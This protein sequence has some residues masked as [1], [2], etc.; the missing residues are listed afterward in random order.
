MPKAT[1]LS[2]G[3]VAMLRERQFAHMAT[4]M[5]DGSPQTTVVWIDVEA[6]GAHILVNSSEKRLKMRNLR[7]DPRVC[8]SVLDPQDSRRFVI[9]RGV[10]ADIRPEG[11]QDHYQAL[12]LKYD[13]RRSDRRDLDERRI[14]RIKPDHVVEQG[15]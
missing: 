1:N 12:S 10:V 8:I 4:L 5:P 7:R 9:L 11:A 6:D 13:G 2:P 15:V 14:I 3:A